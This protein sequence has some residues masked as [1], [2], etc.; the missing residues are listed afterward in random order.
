MIIH[1]QAFPCKGE[2]IMTALRRWIPSATLIGFAVLCTAFIASPTWASITGDALT[3]TATTAT[4][5]VATISIPVPSGPPPWVWESDQTMELRSQTTGDLLGL[6][7]PPGYSSKVEYIDD[8]FI[9]VFFAVLSGPSPTTFVIASGLLSFP[10]IDPAEG[11]ATV[12]FTVTDV[13][14]DGVTLTGKNINGD[15]YLAQYNGLAPTGTTFAS[16]IPGLAAGSLST[17]T[18]SAA[19]PAVGFAPIGAPVS[20]MSVEVNFELSANDLA[21]GTSQYVIQ[22]PPTSVEAASWGG[23]KGLYR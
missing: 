21:S 17:N 5:D 13:N 9:A 4:G 8:P 18:A 11:R 1:P 7:N 2:H 6:L 15:S 3:I 14:G 16:L 22:S 23:I 19:V 20:D 12:G 10:T